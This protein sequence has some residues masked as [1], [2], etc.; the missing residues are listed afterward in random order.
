MFRRL[1]HFSGE[2]RRPTTLFYFH[3]QLL[4]FLNATDMCQF[5]AFSGILTSF[6]EMEGNA[7]NSPVDAVW[8]ENRFCSSSLPP[9]CAAETSVKSKAVSIDPGDLPITTLDTRLSRDACK[10]SAMVV[11]MMRRAA[12][13]F[14]LPC[15]WGTAAQAA[16]VTGWPAFSG[17][18]GLMS[19]QD[20]EQSV[21]VIRNQWMQ[22]IYHLKCSICALQTILKMK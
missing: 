12:V 21:L 1:L 11:V 7:A 2:K 22:L 19:N 9:S 8:Q 17:V 14:V 5:W 4:N 13:L 3:I 6:Q 20:S 10:I 18:K 16:A 15:L